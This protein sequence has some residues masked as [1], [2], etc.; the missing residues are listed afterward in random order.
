MSGNIGK[1]YDRNDPMLVKKNVSFSMDEFSVFDFSTIQ[2]RTDAVR[3]ITDAYGLDETTDPKWEMHLLNAY[4][5]LTRMGLI[6]L[7][8]REMTSE[9]LKVFHAGTYSASV[10][11][12]ALTSYIALLHP[13]FSGYYPTLATDANYRITIG[14]WYFDP[15]VTPDNRG[16]MIVHEIMHGVLGHHQLKAVDPEV[17]NKA[18]DDVINQQIERSPQME[19]PQNPDRSDILLFPRGIRTEEYPNGM[20]EGLSFWDYY[21]AQMDE[22]IQQITGGAGGS[23]QSDKQQDGDDKEDQQGNSGDSN[24]EGESENGNGAGSQSGDSENGSEGD[25]DG[26]NGSG[27]ES[28]ENGNGSGEGEDSGNNGQCSSSG[29]GGDSEGSGSGNGNGGSSS[30]GS[31]SSSSNGNGDGTESGSTG[32]DGDGSDSGNGGNGSDSNREPSGAGNGSGSV[33]NGDGFVD[34]SKVGNING[35]GDPNPNPCH[36]MTK[37]ESDSLDGRGIQKTTKIEEDMARHEALLHAMELR[38]KGRSTSGSAFNDFIINAIRPA[39]L[40]WR[41]MLSNIVSR[42]YTS[43][44]AGNMD[45]SYRRPNRRRMDNSD[46]IVFPGVIGYAPVVVVGCDTSGSMGEADYSK[47]LGEVDGI[48][49]QSNLPHISFLTVDTEITGMKMVSNVKDVDLTGGGGTIMKVFYDYIKTMK[50]NR[51][52]MTVLLTDGGIDWE[53]SVNAINPK[54]TNLILVT[55]EGGYEEYKDL[56]GGKTIRGL[57]V[58]PIFNDNKVKY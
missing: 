25:G 39:R 33:E 3:H 5:M 37:E 45:S 30:G 41:K 52:D 23:S 42:S 36:D 50:R 54:I 40:D 49:R 13:S 53:D 8:T 31:Q 51:P 35:I 7:N 57:K 47:A 34:G 19:L 18:G 29:T 44:V 15:S 43:I 27:E 16:S 24:E 6:G 58:L 48:L 21:N 56:Y 12:P 55:D 2:G 9:E 11:A 26:K 10:M 32:N 20:D 4:G 17:S 38:K 28:G 22:S 46:G 14:A 1:G